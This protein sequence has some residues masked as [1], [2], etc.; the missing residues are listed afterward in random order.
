[1]I[2][3]ASTCWTRAGACRITTS[4]CS[5]SPASA[6]IGLQPQCTDRCGTLHRPTVRCSG[7]EFP[8]FEQIRRVHNEYR[9]GGDA[10]LFGVKLTVLHFWE[11]FQRG[12]A[13]ALGRSAGRQQL[14]PTT[15]PSRRSRSQPYHGTSPGWLVNLNRRTELVGGQRTVHLCGRRPELHSRRN[16]GRHPAASERRE[17]SSRGRR[18]REPPCHHRRSFLEF[19]SRQPSDAGEQHRFS[20]RPH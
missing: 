16:R 19:F 6:C 18:Q 17:P 10:A 20:Q 3:T 11:R 13:D 1:M 5:R 8:L 4:R 15:T 14:R 12:F 9:V 7:D 2:A